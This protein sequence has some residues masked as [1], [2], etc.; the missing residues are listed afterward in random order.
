MFLPLIFREVYSRYLYGHQDS[1]RPMVNSSV[2]VV[3]N[4]IL[5]VA[6]CPR[7][8]VLG[9]TAASSISVALCGVLDLRSA[10]KLSPT[11]SARPYLRALPW[12]LTGCAAC[13]VTA[14]LCTARLAGSSPLVR[15]VLTALLGIAAYAL[16]A[17]P[18]LLR[19]WRQLRRKPE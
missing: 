18:L 12:L 8:G 6:L 5:S 4:I 16:A 11:L 1:K 19:L 7:F 9:V 2:A 17:A 15:F 3:C 14:W 10:V 13:G